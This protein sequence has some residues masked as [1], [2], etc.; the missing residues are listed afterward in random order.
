MNQLYGTKK[1]V[2]ILLLGSILFVCMYDVLYYAHDLG[3]NY[4]IYLLMLLAGTYW[5]LSFHENVNRTV[6]LALSAV[7]M[8][9]SLQ[10]ML[11]TNEVFEALNFLLI[12]ILYF[13]TVLFSLGEYENTVVQFLS[14]VFVPVAHMDM[15]IRCGTGLM[16]TTGVAGKKQWGKILLAFCLRPSLSC[17]FCR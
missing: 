8:A 5:A 1:N 12:P 9:L 11:F 15:F 4:P 7:M 13:L 16:R 3:I 6:F 2:A 10:Y 17:S 14:S